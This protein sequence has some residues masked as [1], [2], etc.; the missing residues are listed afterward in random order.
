MDRWWSIFESLLVGDGLVTLYA[1]GAIALL[2][3]LEQIR[4]AEPGQGWRG[5]ARNLVFLVQFKVLGL[6]ALAAWIAFG[7]TFRPLR[8]EPDPVW[9]FALVGLNLLAI[10]L[11]YY[12][13]HR[14]QHRFRFLWALHEL[15]HADSELNATSSYRTYWLEVPVQ[16]I[17]VTT[18]TVLLFGALGPEHGRLV[19]TGSLFF[20]I[21]SHSNLRLELGPLTG[22]LVGPQVHRIH[23][24]RLP[25]HRD[26]NFAQYFA[27]LDRLFGTW[28]AP[29]AGEFPPTGADDLASDAPLGTVLARP[30][31]IWAG[32][33]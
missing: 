14:A 30:F 12:V 21:F 27:F 7:P 29:A 2:T 15:H 11:C 23:H 28:R 5:R 32:R 19:L 13:Y 31:R 22:W 8:L 9:A 16:T 26:R 17:L 3:L 1:L 33:A 10:D 20:L 18:P 6:A 4:P 24:S 25:G